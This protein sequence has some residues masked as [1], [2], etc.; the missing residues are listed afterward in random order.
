[1]LFIHLTPFNEDLIPYRVE[2]LCI[3]DDL[4][5]NNNENIIITPP[6]GILP[7][8]SYALALDEDMILNLKNSSIN[9][10]EAGVKLQ[11]IL[12]N[13]NT[14]VFSNSLSLQLFKK[15]LTT[16][17]LPNLLI[18][19]KV[20]N[21]KALLFTS[22]NLRNVFK[23]EFNGSIRALG[24]Q[25][26][27]K[28]K[29]ITASMFAIFKQLY[30]KEAKLMQFFLYNPQNI[31]LPDGKLTQLG[32]I[33]IALKDDSCILFYPISKS[34][35]TMIA[36]N[37]AIE[38]TD[39]YAGLIYFPL[40]GSV[41]FAPASTVPNSLMQKLKLDAQDITTRR[42]SLNNSFANEQNL[43]DIIAHGN[44]EK[45]DIAELFNNT[46]YNMQSQLR[47]DYISL[48]SN[49]NKCKGYIRELVLDYLQNVN[50]ELLESHVIAAYRYIIEERVSSKRESFTML[51]NECLTKNKTTNAETRLKNIYSYITTDL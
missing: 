10:A 25:L 6:P 12:E 47:L 28:D 1:M 18:N 5:I 37:L 34:K 17:L 24:S 8:P 15:I 38:P 20:V 3:K 44:I 43:A 26:G 22:I 27:A 39:K 42:N 11:N 7:N 13:E 33:M 16:L 14:L 31:T 21:F 30:L 19:K 45:D 40:N 4:Q 50:S 41:L 46:M 23:N 9:Y 35:T 48:N 32:K 36:W 51:F 2:F 49:I 29:T